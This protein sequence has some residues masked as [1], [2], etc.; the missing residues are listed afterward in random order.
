MCS[1]PSQCVRDPP[2]Y[3]NQVFL[4]GGSDSLLTFLAPGSALGFMF[5]FIHTPSEGRDERL[6]RRMCDH[7]GTPAGLETLHI[8]R[9][10]SS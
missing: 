6:P 4:K 8:M 1:D 5:L 10:I 2:E 9:E 3:Y 7:E